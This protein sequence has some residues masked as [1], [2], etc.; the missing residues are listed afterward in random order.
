VQSVGLTTDLPWTG[1]D[2]N[3]GFTIE[4]KTFPPN[5]G[6]SARYHN[7]SADYFRTIGVPLVAGRFFNAEDRQGMPN[8]VLINHSMAERYW[9]GE[10]AVGKR[11]SFASQPREQDW[12]TVVGVV[13]DVKD[14]PHSAAAEPAFYWS[15]AQLQARQVILAVRTSAEPLNSVEAVRNAVRALDNDLPLADVK[16]LAT[17]ATAAVAGQRFTLWLVGF[18]ALVALVLAAIGIYS[19]LSYL[20]AQRTQEIG[21][22]MALGAQTR[23]VLKL[24]LWQGARLILAGVGLGLVASFALTRWL[25]R[26]LFEVSATDPLTFGAV[27]LLLASIALVACWLPARRAARL[28]PLIALRYE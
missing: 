11:F 19:V 10:S 12:F 25:N 21:L 8:V 1:Y 14:F 3:A 13:G 16:P 22:R 23:D 9:P 26:L 27:A 18:F 6:P 20:V 28:D 7:V 4:G 17:I 2:E 24:M 15:T 5:Q